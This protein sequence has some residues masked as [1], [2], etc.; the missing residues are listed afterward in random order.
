MRS[1]LILETLLIPV[2]KL[3]VLARRELIDDLLQYVPIHEIIDDDMREGLSVLVLRCKRAACCSTFVGIES[4]IVADKVHAQHHAILQ[5]A[6][7]KPS[8]SL[9]QLSFVRLRDRQSQ[10]RR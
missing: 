10:L 9:T 7:T 3:F 6:A 5:G 8:S 4:E 2:E 1:I